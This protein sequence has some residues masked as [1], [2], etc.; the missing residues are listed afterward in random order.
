MAVRDV[1]KHGSS[2]LRGNVARIIEIDDGVLQL[3]DDLID[4]M[5][6]GATPG[7][8]LAAPQIDVARAV[9]VAEPPP[10]HEGSD[11]VYRGAVAL[12]NPELVVASGPSV[13]IEE[14]CLSCPGVTAEVERPGSVIIKGLDRDGVDVRLEVTGALARIFQHE[15]DHLKG[16][17]FFDHLNPIKRQLVKARIRRT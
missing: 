15:I 5:R 2:S 16:K 6:D 9:I 12:I 3:I 11:A 8:G 7:V 17:F 4:T 10:D 14:G 1:V 13:V